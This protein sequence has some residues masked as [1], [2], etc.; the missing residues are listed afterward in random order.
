MQFVFPLIDIFTTGLCHFHPPPPQDRLFAG[1]TVDIRYK[2][3]PRMHVK[4]QRSS[5]VYHL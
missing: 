2:N 3:K 5:F 4:S 1:Y